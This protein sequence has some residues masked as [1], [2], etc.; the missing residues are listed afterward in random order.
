MGV[1]LGR[2]H[3]ALRG[4]RS[5]LLAYVLISLAAALAY[6]ILEA[7]GVAAPRKFPTNKEVDKLANP[8]SLDIVVS[9]AA[10]VAGVTMVAARRFALLAGPLMALALIPSAAMAGAAAA[11]GEEKLVL[12]AVERL[13]V[14]VALIFALGAGVS[15]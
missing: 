10:A 14:D 1:V 15:V 13:G 8:L 5:A 9:S 12:Q 3:T 6:L 11:M 4:L 7:S 2:W